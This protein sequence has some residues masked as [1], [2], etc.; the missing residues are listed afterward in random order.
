MV[1][2][3][4]N[5][6]WIPLVGI[7]QAL[8]GVAV[9]MSVEHGPHTWCLFGRPAHPMSAQ[10]TAKRWNGAAPPRGRSC[11][12]SFTLERESRGRARSQVRSGVQQLRSAG[13]ETSPLQGNGV[14]PGAFRTGISPGVPLNET[15]CSLGVPGF[16]AM[17]ASSAKLDVISCQP[18]EPLGDFRRNLVLLY[19][20]IQVV[21]HTF[22]DFLVASIRPDTERLVR[23]RTLCLPEALDQIEFFL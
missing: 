17:P 21:S 11:I 6:D 15:A 9:I 5:I 10:E 12:T 22:G 23:I 20:I 4:D 13:P 14:A 1:E 18:F 16:S 7:R 2:A 8:L 19:D 3:T